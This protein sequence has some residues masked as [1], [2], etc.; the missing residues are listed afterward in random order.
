MNDENEAMV[1]SARLR[2]ESGLKRAAQARVSELE[3]E[4]ASLVKRADA[5]ATLASE[6]ETLRAT[7]TSAL[8]AWEQ[9]RA[10][11]QLGVTDPEAI[12]VARHL[13]ARLPEAGRPPLAEWLRSVRETP[14]SAPRAL[15]PYFLPTP[16]PS[17]SAPTPSASSGPP[18]TAQRPAATAPAAGQGRLDAAQIREMTQEAVRTGD[19]SRLRDALPAI[20]ASVRNGVS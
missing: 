2:E 1:P 20:R 9:E 10:V 18:A 3:A 16:S 12:E 7:H 15:Q 17:P 14:A 6:L 4:V 13:H 8:A 11:Y 19:Y 5:A